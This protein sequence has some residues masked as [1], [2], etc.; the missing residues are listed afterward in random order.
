MKTKETEKSWLR[1]IKKIEEREPTEL[2]EEY[3]KEY[4][5]A[6]GWLLVNP[7]SEEEAS[8]YMFYRKTS[9]NIT[10]KEVGA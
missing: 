8:R 6:I 7:V 2:T 4:L 3:C 1:I 9:K 10:K 5:R